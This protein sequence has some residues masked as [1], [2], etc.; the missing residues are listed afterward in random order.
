VH[1]L[2]TGVSR[3]SERRVDVVEVRLALRSLLPL[4]PERWPLMLYW[5]A[6]SQANNIGR[7]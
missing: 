3:C 4:C 1:I 7:A 5:D 6:A 2:R